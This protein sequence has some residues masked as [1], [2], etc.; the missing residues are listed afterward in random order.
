MR[1]T[2][3]VV[4]AIFITL[5]TLA[6]IFGSA[7]AQVPECGHD[8]RMVEDGTCVPSS[9]H[10][11]TYKPDVEAYTPQYSVVSRD[12]DGYYHAIHPY[13]KFPE[14]VFTSIDANHEVLIGDTVSIS[15]DEYGENP[16]VE[17]EGI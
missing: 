13:G 9:F 6:K 5:L 15:L 8:E 7:G 11:T 10:N 14:V 1:K 16:I 3:R 2:L 17:V 4:F 12:D